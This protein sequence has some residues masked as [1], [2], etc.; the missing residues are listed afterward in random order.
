MGSST[1]AIHA[2]PAD[3][4]Q[5]LEIANRAAAPPFDLGRADALIRELADARRVETGGASFPSVLRAPLKQLFRGALRPGGGPRTPPP[6][7][8][9]PPGVPLPVPRGVLAPR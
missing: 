8:P 6:L 7:P 5:L 2:S 4:D 1:G 9:L 3:G